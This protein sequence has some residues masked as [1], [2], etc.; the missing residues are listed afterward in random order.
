[1]RIAVAG[2][3]AMGSIFG[4]SIAASGN[5]VL[6]VD[7]AEPIVAKATTEGL[8]IERDGE[9]R[10]Q[11]VEATT[12]PAGMD[13]VDL[14]FV[15]VKG[16]HTASAMDLCAPLVEEGTTV[17]SLQNGWGNAD[18]VRRSVNDESIVVGVTNNSGT[19]RKLGRIAHTGVGA[20]HLGPY[21]EGA[22]MDRA[23][24]VADVLA[25]AG[26]EV[27]VQEQVR[28]EIWKKLVLNAATLPTS[29]LTGLTAGALGKPGEMLDLVDGV[30]REAVEVAN[31]SGQ[32][33]DVDERVE[34]IHALLAR[35]GD[36]KASML[37]DVEAGRRTEIDT[38][39]GAV[40]RL[41]EEMAVETPLNTTM[42]ALVR[43]WERAKGMR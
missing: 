24:T 15:F 6:L 25:T 11:V 22:G 4:I 7:V 1:M 2:A 36:G 37:Q 5:E 17:V 41:G 8:T 27:D 31:A 43:G 20:T 30:A 40:T 38:I 39:N 14:L 13:P 34:F 21:V 23:E 29:A 12:D 42:V 9:S 32:D 16:Y 35:A 26:F 3:G 28:V 33:L 18:V 19:V 10:T